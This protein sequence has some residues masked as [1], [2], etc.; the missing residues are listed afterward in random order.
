[1]RG[2]GVMATGVA[3]MAAG[4]A[5]VPSASAAADGPVVRV[6]NGTVRCQIS[7]ADPS[8]DRS[9]VTCGRADGTPFGSSPMS[10]EKYPRKLNLAVVLETGERYWQAG[11]IPGSAADDVVLG[12]G[13]TH[14]A[15][16][17]T[18]TSQG[19]RTVIK[20]DASGRTLILND[21]GVYQ[22]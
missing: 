17:W 18:I 4:A 14:H 1:M 5:A 13:Q 6:Q 15:G 21:V 10:T 22:I 19:A 11:V 20:N 9:Q 8:H 7:D 3:L 12:L 2:L 16:G